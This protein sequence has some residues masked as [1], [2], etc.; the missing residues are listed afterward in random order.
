MTIGPAP[1]LAFLVGV[2]H[3][4]LFVFIRGDAG[5]RRLPIFVIAAFFGAWVGDG[6]GARVA[7]D[8]LTLG[9]FHLLTASI[10]AW[11]AIGIVAIVGILAPSGSRYAR[12]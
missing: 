2:L 12:R 5:G 7:L 6:I 1:I 4:A 8:W 10:V 11:L 9:D 3:T